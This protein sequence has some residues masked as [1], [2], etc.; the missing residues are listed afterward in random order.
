MTAPPIFASNIFGTNANGTDQPFGTPWLVFVDSLRVICFVLV[1]IFVARLV[2]GAVRHVHLDWWQ[3]VTAVAVLV[4]SAAILETEWDHFGHG[5]GNGGRLFM[6]L[7]AL[8]MF[9]VVFP[10]VRWAF[11]RRSNR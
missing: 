5:V 11:H 9:V 3:T 1:A 6:N 7:A 4:A 8:A 10:G 2:V